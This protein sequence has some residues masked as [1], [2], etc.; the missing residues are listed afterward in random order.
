M[1][2]ARASSIALLLLVSACATKP[3]TDEAIAFVQPFGAFSTSGTNTVD[4]GE[5]IGEHVTRAVGAA[6]S[7]REVRPSDGKI[8]LDRLRI[9]SGEVL[10][11]VSRRNHPQTKTF[12]GL[13]L[14]S[15]D[16]GPRGIHTCV[17][18]ENGNGLMD[19]VWA[20]VDIYGPIKISGSR[21]TRQFLLSEEFALEPINTDQYP[22]M[23]F[24]VKTDS[25][26]TGGG[27]LTVH[28]AENKRI[29]YSFQFSPARFKVEELPKVVVIGGAR[30][31]VLSLE[32]GKLTLEVLAGFPND[33]P[34]GIYVAV[35]Q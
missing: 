14:S 34:V 3:V 24:S 12:C 31:R 11:E 1:M 21:I 2:K 7:P 33:V 20:L 27:K 23:A 29:L 4:I 22:T 8:R 26:L 5:S 19:T 13:G 9:A 6:R 17:S 16:L 28:S 18:D 15:P 35:P 30:F 32:N 25:T 10:Y